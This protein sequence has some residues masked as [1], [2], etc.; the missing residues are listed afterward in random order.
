MPLVGCADA[1]A[2][3]ASLRCFLDGPLVECIVESG[4]DSTAISGHAHSLMSGVGLFAYG[5]DGSVE[6]VSVSVEAWGGLHL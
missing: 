3:S 2:V 5:G 1:S 6:T 4:G